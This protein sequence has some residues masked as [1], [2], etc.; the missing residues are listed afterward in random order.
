MNVRRLATWMAVVALVVA[1]ATAVAGEQ[2][3]GFERGDALITP[4][5][6][7]SMMDA[8]DPKLV[9]LGVVKGGLT[10]SFTRG[11]IPGAYSVWRPDYTAASG[12]TY[13]VGAEAQR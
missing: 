8:K 11:H 9:L 2:Y 10:G 4:A 1:S 12:E 6:L 5:G 7:K 13:P 3:K